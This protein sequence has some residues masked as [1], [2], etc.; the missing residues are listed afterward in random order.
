MHHKYYCRAANWQSGCQSARRENVQDAEHTNQGI[1]SDSAPSSPPSPQLTGMKWNV[2]KLS[3]LNTHSEWFWVISSRSRR[4]STCSA[5]CS[6]KRLQ[7]FSARAP[8]SRVSGQTDCLGKSH[9]PDNDQRT[10]Y[11][12]AIVVKS[13]NMHRPNANGAAG[14]CQWWRCRCSYCRLGNR[15]ENG[16]GSRNGSMSG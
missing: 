5:S 15:N 4:S 7:C 2:F 10:V 12:S 14:W 1:L 8:T 9:E 13:S 3:L 11:V 16:N 6:C